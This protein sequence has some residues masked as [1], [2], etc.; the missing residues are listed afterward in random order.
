MHFGA[1]LIT[2][3]S[4]MGVLSTTMHNENELVEGTATSIVR[5]FG[6]SAEFVG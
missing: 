4:S 3:Q 2:L 5:Q 1:T 6:R